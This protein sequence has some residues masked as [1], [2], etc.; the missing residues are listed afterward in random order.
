M[1]ARVSFPVYQSFSR[2][3]TRFACRLP[4]RP[5]IKRSS[6]LTLR[7]N[8]GTHALPPL[9]ATRKFSVDIRLLSSS[10]HSENSA[11]QED[12]SESRERTLF[13][14]NFRQ[15][16]TKESLRNHFSQ[17]GVIESFT[18]AE[19]KITKR[20]RGY[21]FVTYAKKED[22]KN[23]LRQSHKLFGCQLVVHVSV[24]KAPQLVNT[25]FIHVRN[26][27]AKMRKE[28]L[29]E[30]FSTFGTVDAIDW[31]VDTMTSFKRDFCFVQFSSTEE[32][33][34]AARNENQILGGQEILVQTSN[35]SICKKVASTNR[36]AVYADTTVEAIA[37]YFIK[38]GQIDA[39]WG[40]FTVVG[41]NSTIMPIFSLIFKEKH[42]V[43]EISKKSHFI[44]DKEVFTLR[45]LPKPVLTY[46]FEKKV[47]VD[48][49]P[50]KVTIE[51]IVLYF[52]QF[53]DVQQCQFKEDPVTRK[54]L[55]YT[56]TFKTLEDV[57][58]VMVDEKHKLF[59]KE[60][61]VRRVGYR[62]VGETMLNILNAN[63]SS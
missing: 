15:P 39:V 60:V 57:Q 63:S 13:V 49:L 7:Q 33:E 59:G 3:F 44:K 5:A 35:S 10:E 23:V 54:I 4:A 40:N 18:W 55:N 43:D 22:F 26:V 52:R 53:G 30:H 17:F 37:R 47:V 45:C 51:D 21:A 11:K 25:C 14:T 58:R 62:H 12:A 29:L 1:Y 8:G 46:P 9:S 24:P 50:D 32:A 6:L 2:L 36:L 48:E 34:E 19:T 31:P 61:R 41:A 28:D 38:F 20:A 42:P 16:V 27:D 56:V